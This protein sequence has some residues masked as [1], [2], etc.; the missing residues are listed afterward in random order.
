MRPT[1][2]LVFLVALAAALVAGCRSRAPA[3]RDRSA[4]V[5]TSS[6]LHC[7]AREFL[8]DGA[9]SCLVPPG[10]CPGHF[11]LRPSQAAGLRGSAMLVRFDFQAKLDDRLASLG[12][13]R[14]PIVAVSVP[15]GLCIPAK[16]LQACRQ[17]G[18]AM[19]EAGMLE[20]TRAAGRL[21]QVE[22]RLGRLQAQL[23]EATRKAGAAGAPVLATTRQAAFCRH[24]GL[25]VVGTFS[26]SDTIRVSEIKDC[27]ARGREANV[28]CVIG[29]LQEGSAAAT[30]LG[31][32]LAVPVVMF[33]NF[34]DTSSGDGSGFDAMVRHN[35]SLLLEKAF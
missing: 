18:E 34:P 5:T 4:V 7:V 23:A 2:I 20:Q 28:R 25:E 22:A 31:E 21:E 19:V 29:N 35:V 8:E 26:A 10:M 9:V 30:R 11:D 32:Q 17:V 6:Y 33:S 1:R 3:G 24:L 27:L 16:Y 13:E 12:G 15:E 14:P